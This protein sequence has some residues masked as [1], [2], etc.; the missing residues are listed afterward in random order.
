MRGEGWIRDKSSP[1]RGNMQQNPQAEGLF[2]VSTDHYR[3]P[4][5]R[6]GVN[7][8]E[9]RQVWCKLEDWVPRVLGDN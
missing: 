8:N 1:G 4:C 9:R 7:K 3:G 2:G 5:V 6:S